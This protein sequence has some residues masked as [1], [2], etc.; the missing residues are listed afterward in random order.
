MVSAW[1]AETGAMGS[2]WEARSRHAV[3]VNAKARV[4][5]ALVV[6]ASI[7]AMAARR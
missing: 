5:V 6:R 4:S 3:V 2:V 1:I 7:A